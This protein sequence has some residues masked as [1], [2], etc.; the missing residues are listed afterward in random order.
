MGEIERCVSGLILAV[1][2]APILSAQQTK[3]ISAAPV[4]DQIGNAKKVFIS[5][6]GVDEISLSA[7]EQLGDPNKPYNEFYA[8]MKNWGHYDLVGSPSDADLV[9][10]IRFAAPLTGS[11]KLNTYAPQYKVTI[12]DAKT[13]FI[14]W[15]LAE[16]VGGALRRSAFLKNLDQG[17]GKLMD[18]LQKLAT[19][20]TTGAQDRK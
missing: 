20:I 14:L 1:M 16:P 19:P 15:S 11:D 10:E 18:K 3:D 12:L 2:L 5:N 4:P 9:F 13:H 6:A 17:M 8:A 7:F